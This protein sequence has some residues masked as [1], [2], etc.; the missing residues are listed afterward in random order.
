MSL[1]RLNRI[2][3]KTHQKK[4]V[5]KPEN[6]TKTHR[7]HKMN[8]IYIEFFKAFS[9]LLMQCQN[10][11]LPESRA[12]STQFFTQNVTKE[13]VYQIN[14]T[15]ILGPDNNT[16]PV[17]TFIPFEEKGLPVLLFFHGGG[18]AFG[19][20]EDND[21][22][23]RKI[24]NRAKCIV[25]SV[26]YRLAPE[27]Q[28]PKGLE[29]CYAAT[30]WV[31][32]NASTFGGDPSRIA[33]GGESAGA[34]LA[35][36]VALLSRDRKEFELKYQLLLYPAT[37]NDLDP[38]TYAE[39][40]DQSFITFDAMSLF[41]NLYLEKPQD[42]NSPYASPLK[43]ENLANLPP[44]FIVTGEF[45]PLRTEGEAY[46]QRLQEFNVPVKCKRYLGAIHGFLSTPVQD[47]PERL[48]AL[49]DIQ[50]QLTKVFTTR[51]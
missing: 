42:G 39:S 41:W 3:Q 18:W 47:L 40:M 4:L 32:D 31:H 5:N 26:E 36:A 1:F 11:P 23:C 44:A 16:I 27:N 20:I 2:N 38:K 25:V 51:R 17:R 6:L 13:P 21:P 34:N 33:V 28:F 10:M 19:S 35:T 43:A 48:D 15:S 37:T 49:Q 9:M 7:V 46:A 29:D 8:P 24:A 12:A 50:E 22:L 14:N 30:K 45:D